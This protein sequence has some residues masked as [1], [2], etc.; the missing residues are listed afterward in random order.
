MVSPELL[1]RHSVFRDASDESLRRLAMAGE[2]K[3]LE[4]G[5]VLFRDGEPAH[6][7]YIIIKGEVDIVHV[8]NDDSSS[9]VDTLVAGDLLAWSAVVEPFRMTATAVAKRLTVVLAV[10]AAVV[11]EL[12]EADRALG[13]GVMLEVTKVLSHRLQG[14][15]VQLATVGP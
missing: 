4:P 13:Y 15:R 5:A 12:C 10:T 11:R 3:T 7:L 8:L 2:E 14:A 6:H 1:R 9:T